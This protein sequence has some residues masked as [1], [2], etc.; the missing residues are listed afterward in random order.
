MNSRQACI[1]VLSAFF[2]ASFLWGPV[3]FGQNQVA[4]QKSASEVQAEVFFERSTQ[5]AGV[6][7]PCVVSSNYNE[8]TI[9]LSVGIPITSIANENMQIALQ[10][11][12]KFHHKTKHCSTKLK[13]R[14]LGYLSYAAECDADRVLVATVSKSSFCQSVSQDLPNM[15]Q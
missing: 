8:V 4:M 13:I 7:I 11:F 1:V 12:V 3:S 15:N 6:S 14:Q 10:D 9:I 5:N 2:L